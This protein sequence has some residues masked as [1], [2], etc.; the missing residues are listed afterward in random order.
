MG[1]TPTRTHFECDR[2]VAWRTGRHH[3][4]NDLQR[5]RFVLHQRRARPF[6][7][8]F[9]SRTA[10]VDVNDLRTT[11]NVVGRSIGH[12]GCIGA[13]DLHGNRLG[14]ALMVGTA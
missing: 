9:F 1:L 10:H 14:L 8:D 5:Q 13:S 3:G 12:H 6:V 11:V 2:Y 7:T 4:L